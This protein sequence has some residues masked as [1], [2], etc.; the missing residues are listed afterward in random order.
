MVEQELLPNEWIEDRVP[1][2]TDA[3]GI[4]QG[5]QVEVTA[6]EAIKLWQHEGRPKALR[7]R[8]NAQ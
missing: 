3:R 4:G 5:V 2:L 7:A 6:N 8:G 1:K